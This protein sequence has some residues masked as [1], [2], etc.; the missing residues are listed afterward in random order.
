MQDKSCDANSRGG[1]KQSIRKRRCCSRT[2][3]NRQHQKNGSQKNHA[4]EAKYND[5]KRCQLFLLM[6]QK[7]ALIHTVL[8]YTSLSGLY[9]TPHLIKK[10]KGY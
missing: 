10:V 8:L 2:G 5:L 7:N 3:G 9:H 6:R 1:C 4:Q